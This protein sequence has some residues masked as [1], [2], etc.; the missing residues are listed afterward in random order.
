LYTVI[1]IIDLYK[2][3]IKTQIYIFEFL[4]NKC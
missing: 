1:E 4:N 3:K 2:A